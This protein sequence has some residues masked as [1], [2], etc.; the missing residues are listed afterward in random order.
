M[1]ATSAPP[2]PTAD[3]TLPAD[4]L[5]SLV[6]LRTLNAGMEAIA[7]QL[8]PAIARVAAIHRHVTHGMTELCMAISEARNDE[9]AGIYDT[10]EALVGYRCDGVD[11]L[12]GLLVD[13]GN[14]GVP[15]EP[16]YADLATRWGLRSS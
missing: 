7:A 16:R 1:H 11:L 14:I 2:R 10:V 9:P 5:A 8:V 3:T 12:V 4:L 6:A 15:T 13:D